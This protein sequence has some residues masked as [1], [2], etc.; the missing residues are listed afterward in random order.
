MNLFHSQTQLIIILIFLVLYL[1]INITENIVCDSKDFGLFC[2][3]LKAANLDSSFDKET[4]TV[5]IPNDE[6]IESSG[7]LLESLSNDAITNIV[8]WCVLLFGILQ[9]TLL[10]NFALLICS[11]PLVFP[12]SLCS[13]PLLVKSLAVMTWSVQK[14]F[15]CSMVIQV[16]P[17]VTT[18]QCIRMVLGMT[19]FRTLL[20]SFKLISNFVRFL[21]TCLLSLLFLSLHYPSTAHFPLSISN[22][23]ALLLLFSILYRQWSCPRCWWSNVP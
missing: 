2:D 1:F 14:K 8:R 5:F 22:F 6:A 17:N 15:K 12:S 7:E 18:M 21:Y 16:A 13:T 11:L 3:A 4:W 9:S 20:R 23:I 10:R 19:N